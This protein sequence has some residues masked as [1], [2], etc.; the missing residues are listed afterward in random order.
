MALPG[1][2]FYAKEV[3]DRGILSP[4]FYLLFAV[5]LIQCAINHEFQLGRLVPPFPQNAD[6]PFPVVQYANDTIFVM[7]GDEQQ[8]LIL[9]DILQKIAISGSLKVNYHKSCLVPI[10]VDA[11]KTELLA[12]SSGC[13]VDPFLLR[14]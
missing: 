6:L 14:T 11:Q 4:L 3:F 7:Q 13:I 5:D 12:T 2:N 8:L 9:K 10:N 1:K